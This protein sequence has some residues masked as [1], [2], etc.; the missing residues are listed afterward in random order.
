MVRAGICSSNSNGNYISQKAER[1]FRPGCF[2]GRAAGLLLDCS[3]L[4][5]QQGACV[6]ALLPG[7]ATVILLLRL[8][9]GILSGISKC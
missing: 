7:Q 8:L 6:S 4:N 5:M 2:L 1:A 9:G 3:S